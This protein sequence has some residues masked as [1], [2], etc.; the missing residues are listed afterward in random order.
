MRKR[1]TKKR[2]AFTNVNRFCELHF[3]IW[4]VGQSS[5]EAKWIDAVKSADQT[6]EGFWQ[7]RF[8]QTFSSSNLP[9]K[10]GF[11]FRMSPAKLLE[12]LF[13][14]QSCTCFRPER[15]HSCRAPRSRWQTRPR[16]SHQWPTWHH[17]RNCHTSPL[18]T[19]GH[20]ADLAHPCQSQVPQ[21]F[22]STPSAIK[23]H[24][25]GTTQHP[26]KQERILNLRDRPPPKF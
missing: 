9:A 25:H 18:S 7:W 26:K 8:F 21:T 22:S 6:L 23:Y 24:D 12:W 15:R 20:F 13:V 5:S 14:L 3:G 1:K 4:Q 11:V 2:K 16:G 17:A 10:L 19:S